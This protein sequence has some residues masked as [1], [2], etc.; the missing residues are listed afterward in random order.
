MNSLEILSSMTK[1]YAL[2][3]TQKFRCPQS[4]ATIANSY[5]GILN[6]PRDFKGTLKPRKENN[7]NE[8]KAIICRTNAKLFDICGRKFT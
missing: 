7:E 5:L 2:Y 1:S 8:A 3:L 4:I 6:A